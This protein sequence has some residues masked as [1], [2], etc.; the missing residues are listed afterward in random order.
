VSEAA[1]GEDA[2]TVLADFKPDM[3][4]VDFA[5]QETA[6]AAGKRCPGIPILFIMALPIPKSSEVQSVRRRC[7]TNP[8]S[9]PS[10]PPSCGQTWRLGPRRRNDG[11]YGESE[12]LKRCHFSRAVGRLCPARLCDGR[13]GLSLSGE[14]SRICEGV[15]ELKW[16][17]EASS[18]VEATAR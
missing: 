9:P 7:C 11:I 14:I 10:L 18:N 13:N 2:L 8:S 1:G 12:R 15:C 16:T 4:I 3:I 17:I 5:M 6:L